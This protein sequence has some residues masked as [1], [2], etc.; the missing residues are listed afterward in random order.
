VVRRVAYGSL[1]STVGVAAVER[2]EDVVARLPTNAHGLLSPVERERAQRFRQPE[3]RSSF[4]AAH[5]LAR[6]CAAEALGCNPQEVQIQQRCERCGGPHGKPR[7]SPSQGWAISLAHS[8]GVVAAAVAMGRVGV[9][10]ES[11]AFRNRAQAWDSSVLT[12]NELAM[13]RSAAEA[14]EVSFL[15]IWVAKE[16]LAKLSLCALDTFKDVDVSALLGSPEGR[17]NALGT[18]VT[19]WLDEVRQAVAGVGTGSPWRL[20][21]LARSGFG[22]TPLKDPHPDGFPG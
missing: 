12:P 4:V 11:A 1:V 18:T 9:D 13:I 6:L 3:D 15:R 16:T 21:G 5:V 7:L 20:F 10:V 19:V 8:R 22:L 2:T 14:V 17:V